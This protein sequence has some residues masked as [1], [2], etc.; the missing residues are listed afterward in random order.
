[1]MAKTVRQ[2]KM[3]DLLGHECTNSH[4]EAIV[5]FDEHGKCYS[6]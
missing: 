6:S 4:Y 3:N 1:M 2:F 5:E